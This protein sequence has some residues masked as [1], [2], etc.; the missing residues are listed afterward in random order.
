[1][2][3][4]VVLPFV[5]L[6]GGVRVMLDYANWLH[7]D[8]HQVLVVYPA[9]PY[10]FQMT[11]RQ[12]WV[13]FRRHGF[14]EPG[15]PWLDVR[16]PV[17]RVPVIHSTFIPNADV[18][19][20]T[21]WHTA[22]DVAK[23]PARCGRK[24]HI[25]MHHE[26]GT[27]PETA[28]RS[29]YQLPFY[30]IAFSDFVRRT[31]ATDF[32]VRIDA[33]VPNGVD[34]TLFY[35][36]ADPARDRVLMIYHPDPRKGADDGRAALARLRAI[37]PRTAVHVLGTVRPERWPAD[38]PFEFHPD[39]VTL[40]GRFSTATALLYSS[41]Y[42]GFGL[43][44]LEA[45]SCGCPSVTTSVGAVPEFATD[46]HDAL[47]VEPEDVGAMA[48]RLAELLDDAALRDRL[49]KNGLDTAERYS[50]ARVAPLFAQALVNSVTHASI[51]SPSRAK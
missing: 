44:P 48:D 25:V 41:R 9:W 49:G 22:L 8:G 6:T 5:N 32:G 27:G 11:R 18:V 19:V 30:R 34:R 38:L 43:P 4:T 35:P 20:A 31:I 51:A 29:I 7:A 37:R 36:D 42:E 47:I 24:V 33:V 28:I 10:R 39:D 50:L 17:R 1:M 16:C 23:L 15:V 26:S 12:Q 14:G 3:I 40:R 46:R 13:E 2:R 45:M 21:A